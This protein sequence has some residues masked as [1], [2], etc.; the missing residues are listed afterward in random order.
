MSLIVAIKDKNRFLV[1][2]DTRATQGS[3]YTDGYSLTK[4]ARMVDKS[5]GLIVAGAGTSAICDFAELILKKHNVEKLDREYI[6]EKF[7]P[8]LYQ[9]C[10]KYSSMNNGEIEGEVMILMKDTGYYIDSCGGVMEI[11]DNCSI[12]SGAMIAEAV[13]HTLSYKDS[14]SNYAKIVYC[15]ESAGAVRNDISQESYIGSSDG[16]EFNKYHLTQK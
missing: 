3:H 12:G 14:Y 16:G 8:E 15:I 4:K 10:Y 13:L 5:K 11:I 1:G 7:W 2:C 9:R 6:L